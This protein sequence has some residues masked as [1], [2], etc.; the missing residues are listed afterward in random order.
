M[1]ALRVFVAGH[2]GM[3]G[4]AI[5]RALA[6][7][8]DNELI[9]ASHS[10]LDL[11]DQSA[12]RSFFR[13]ERIDRVYIAAARVGGILANSTYRADFIYENL[14]IQCNLLHEAHRSGVERALFL[15][16]SCIYPRLAQQ[17]MKE[18]ALLTGQLEPTN[19][20]YAIAK[21]AGIEM[22]DAYRRQYGADFRA[23][24]PTNLYGPNDN[25]DLHTSHV[26]PAL[27]RKFHEA[28]Q[29][30]AEEVVIWGSGSP[31]REFLHV[32]DMAEACLLLMDLERDR[33]E[34]LETPHVNIGCGRDISIREL[35]ESIRDI[36]EFEGV[37]T[38]DPSRPD[39]MP[40]K[41]LDISLLRSLGWEPQIPLQQ[42]LEQMYCEMSRS[43]S[44]HSPGSVPAPSDFSARRQKIAPVEK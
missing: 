1:S 25:F 10:E 15:G 2:R 4:S 33:W 6:H 37:L 5:M 43:A 44:M 20:P 23:V 14:Q 9:L 11:L 34:A 21:I 3:V 42:G 36:V 35:A 32:D 18:S 29:S 7:R 31:R 22:C 26:V 40:R 24:M 28:R 16:S 38:F 13:K 27:L 30:G 17:P 19:Q 39:G 41:L 8:G 12:V